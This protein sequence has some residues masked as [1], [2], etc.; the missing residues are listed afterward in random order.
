MVLKRLCV[1]S[2]CLVLGGCSWWP[3]GDDTPAPAAP[4]PKTIGIVSV[5]SNTIH[6][7]DAGNGGWSRRSEIYPLADWQI[8]ALAEQA[9]K[10]WLTQ[11]GFE[12][13]PVVAA[14]SAFGLQALGGPVTRA[15]WF[16]RH[17]P[18]FG[19]IIHSSVQPPDLDYYLILVEASASTSVPD[20]HGI[21]LVRFSGKP[22]AFIA[23]HAFLIDG[24]S[25]ETLDEVHADAENEHWGDFSAIDGPNVDLP[26]SD[27]PRPISDWSAPQQQAFRQA[28]ETELPVS[29][30]ATLP[31]LSLP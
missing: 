2:V 10:D 28:I 23:Y 31:R 22:Q 7:I 4:A 19:T 5:L 20:M 1:L 17:R 16:D 21:G 25:G 26:K 24:K 8:D 15:G 12:V 9:A 13:R 3:W 11:Q 6:V 30:K 14:R 27:W 18:T 29:L